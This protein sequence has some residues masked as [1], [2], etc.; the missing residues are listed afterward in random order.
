METLEVHGPFSFRGENSIFDHSEA[1]VNGF[2]IWCVEVKPSYYRAYYV[3]EALDVAQRHKRHL[4]DCLKGNYQAHCL[5]GLRR[6]QSI[7][8][9]RPGDGMIPRFAHIDREEFNNDFI[10]NMH[11]FFAELPKTGDKK[12]DKLLRCRYEAGVVRH[13]EN[14]GLNVLNVGR[15]S[16]WSGEPSQ[17]QLETNGV[18]IE[19]L[20]GELVSI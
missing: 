14:A 12:A 6:N 8:M 13:I 4:R 7:L 20:S 10:D 9:H 15:I 3:G 18:K 5:D 11:L 17:V 2:Y 19:A 16:N 1:W